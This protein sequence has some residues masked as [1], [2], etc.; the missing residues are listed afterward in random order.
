[1]G[2]GFLYVPAYQNRIVRYLLTLGLAV[3]VISQWKK[4]VAM[5]NAVLHKK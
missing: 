4:A 1:M 5:L 2:V 3:I